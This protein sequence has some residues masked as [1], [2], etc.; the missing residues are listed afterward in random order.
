MSWLFTGGA[1]A[2]S[3]AGG[4]ASNKAIA[5]TASENA[6]ATAAM[7]AQ[8]YDVTKNNL[9][10]KAS[11]LNN[12][13]GME[14]TNLLYQ[15]IDVEGKVSASMAER[16][17]AGQTAARATQQVAVKRELSADQI[18][19]QGESKM[20]DIQNEMRNAKYSYESGQL[21]N[22]I[23]FNNAMS[24]VKSPLQ[25]GLDAVTTGMSVYSIASSVG[26]S[27]KGEK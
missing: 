1:A 19:Q 3:I 5:D 16:N 10:Q 27:K 22:A 20:V 6:T 14:L 17:I 21:S 11:E 4:I 15:S 24:A 13:I 26:G 9:N 12:Q 2:L 7:L 8:N 25:L 23:S 18:R